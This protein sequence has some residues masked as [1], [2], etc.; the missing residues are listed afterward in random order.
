M[1]GANERF[2]VK[3]E[4]QRSMIA[5][6]YTAQEFDVAA[7]EY[8]FENWSST[9]ATRLRHRDIMTGKKKFNDK[10]ALQEVLKEYTDQYSQYSPRYRKS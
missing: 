8:I 1:G 6:A 3:V 5:G 2:F 7:Q 10:T 9:V 4:L